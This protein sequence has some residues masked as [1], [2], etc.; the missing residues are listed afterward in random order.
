MRKYFTTLGLFA[1]LIAALCLWWLH[2]GS[3]GR[4]TLHWHAVDGR[5]TDNNGIISV[6]TYGRGDMQT[7]G[8]E[9][10]TDYTFE[11]DLRYD[12]LFPE[13]HYGDAGLVVRV[14]DASEGVDSYR[15]YYAGLRADDQTLVFGRADFGWRE[16]AEARLQKPIG[17]GQWY[18]MGITVQGCAFSITVTDPQSESTQLRYVDRR[19]KPVGAVGLRSFYAQSS[20][21]NVNVRLRK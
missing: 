19:C 21:R 1:A 10:W 13:T 20:W 6:L 14:S 7:A 11:A 17:M 3:A 4:S 12:L 16:L 8:K 5:W 9:G 15:G 2:T 18:H